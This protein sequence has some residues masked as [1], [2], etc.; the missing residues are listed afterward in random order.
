[1]GE[2]SVFLGDS[3]ENKSHEGEAMLH[4]VCEWMV[5]TIYLHKWARDQESSDWEHEERNVTS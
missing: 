1:M 4:S 3:F 2:K 5:W